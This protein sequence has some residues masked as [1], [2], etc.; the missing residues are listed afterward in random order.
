MGFAILLVAFLVVV[1]GFVLTSSVKIVGQAEVMVIERLGRFHRVARSGMNLLLPGIDRPR[2]ID[3]RVFDT[4]VTG[5][6]RIRSGS[7][8]RIDLREQVLSF[9]SQSVIT[10]DNVSIGI[11][12]VIYYRVA[13]PQKA[14]YAVQNLPFALETLTRTTLRNIVGEMELDQTL[15]S[16]DTINRRMRD[17]IEEASIGWGVDVTRVELQAIEPPH[18]VQQSMELQMRAE[19]ERRAAVTNAEAGKRAAILEAEGV[20]ESA[21][22]RA[23]GMAEARLAMANAEAEAI[24]KI[25]GSLAEGEAAVY[26][27]GLRYFEA[28]PQLAQG[29]GSTIFLPADAAGLLG[30]VGGIRELLKSAVGGA[31]GSAT[32]ATIPKPP[33]LTSGGDGK[34]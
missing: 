17:V 22:L 14:T 10:K 6:K 24:Q 3:V 18:D 5:V 8:A 7:T 11:D 15:G 20:R 26:L 23:Q 2:T 28:L 1:A 19:R 27:L 21:V 33:A 30:A 34:S 16:R 25:S 32:P 31:V 4:D 12:A 29:K 13:D 9:P